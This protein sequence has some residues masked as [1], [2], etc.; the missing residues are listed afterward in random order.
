M[1]KKKGLSDA[2]MQRWWRR[3]V[4]AYHSNTCAVCGRVRADCDLECHH[5]IKR[6]YRILRNDYRN[7]VPVCKGECHRIADNN[8][9]WLLAKH[10]FKDYIT[11]I[12]STYITVKDYLIDW[13]MTLAEFDAQTLEDLKGIVACKERDM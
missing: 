11:R 5:L 8:S 3:A 1:A 10:P 2:T 7:G 4:L 9:G 13:G 12:T 6:R